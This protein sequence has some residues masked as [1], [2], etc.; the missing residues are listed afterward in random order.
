MITIPEGMTREEKEAW[1]KKLTPDEKR[2]FHAIMTP[3]LVKSGKYYELVQKLTL[4]NLNDIK[5]PELKHIT[6][7]DCTIKSIACL[8][9]MEYTKVYKEIFEL[10][11]KDYYMPNDTFH[12]IAPYIEKFGWLNLTTFN[13]QNTMEVGEIITK[14]EDAELLICNRRYGRKVGESA[15]H[16]FGY[17]NHT[18]YNY[19]MDITGIDDIIT[20]DQMT[21]TILMETQC[22]MFFMKTKGL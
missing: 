18:V 2:E 10:A 7:G 14:Y 6:T 17:K 19:P 13:L 5:P 8:L 20:N 11:M 4:V 9:D 22:H 12:V 16:M 3:K 1:Y 15:G 21:L